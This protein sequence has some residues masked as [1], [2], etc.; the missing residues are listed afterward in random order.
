MLVVVTLRLRVLVIK[1][2]GLVN[3]MQCQRFLI[4]IRSGNK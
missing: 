3:P 4:G 1:Q 2:F